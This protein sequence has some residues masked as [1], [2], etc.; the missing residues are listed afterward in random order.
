MNNK[1]L[2]SSKPD[3][4][5]TSFFQKAKKLV[6][7]IPI[8]TMLLGGALT[9][10]IYNDL[11]KRENNNLKQESAQRSR[12]IINQ[13]DLL[14]S[15][16]ILRIQSYEE[17]LGTRASDFRRDRNFLSQSLSYTIFQRMAVF[18]VKWDGN[19]KNLAQI[20]LLTRID[21]MNS[22]LPKPITNTISS[23]FMRDSM[24]KLVMGSEYRRAVLHEAVDVSRFSLILKSRSSK[25]V[26]FMFTTPLSAVFEKVDL[27][28]GESIDITDPDSG[29][30]WTVWNKGDGSQVEPA[31]IA[32]TLKAAS[33]HQYVFEGGLP[34]SGIKINFRFNFLE[35]ENN[36]SPALIAS[37]MV[38]L[39]T[40]L[41]S[42]LFYVLV[43]Q[44][45]IVSRLVVEKTHDLEKTRQDLQE[46]LLGKS[47]FLG[48]ISHEI[49]TPLNLILGMID[50]CEERDKD[51]KLEEYLTS[52]R[53]SGNHLLSMIEDLLDLAKSETNDLQIQPKKMNLAQFL[54]EIAKI[55]GQ[56]CLKKNLR[57][58][59]Q[60]PADLPSVVIC[61][62]SRLRQILLNLL[63]NACKYTNSGYV[64]LRVK[65]LS[66]PG[67]EKMTVRFEVED[68][69]VGIPQD[70][71]SRVFEA[72][73]QVESSYKLSE[74]G[75]GLGLAIVKEL[76]RKL[77]GR[78][79]VHSRPKKGSIFEVDLDFEVPDRS[80][81]VEAYKSA[82]ENDQKTIVAISQDPLFMES[83]TAL[84]SHSN[85]RLFKESNLVEP[86]AQV[87]NRWYILDADADGFSL[88]RALALSKLANVIVAGNRKAILDQRADFPL[89]ILDNAPI[90]S[91]EILTA[92]GLSPA[93]L[94]KRADK[95]EST[96]APVKTNTEVRDD[97]SLIVA[98]DDSGNQELYMAYFESKP[99]KTEYAMNGQE[100]Y[101]LFMKQP[102]DILILDVRMPLMDGFEVAEK[103]RAHEKEHQLKTTPI[104]LVTADALEETVERAGRIPGVTFL[105]KPIRKSVLFD[106]IGKTQ[107][108]N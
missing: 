60:I 38:A 24:Q 102:S 72:F 59:A 96:Q 32:F 69:G 26:I 55:S 8:F 86:K 68:T 47:R 12:E 95:K 44:N 61:D 27:R 33:R 9:V 5:E 94:V 48:N 56:D 42:Y 83:L 17:F 80:S 45:R 97:L 49:R 71:L 93:R 4:V 34:Q 99:W 64:A 13:L 43:T 3:Q 82:D 90:L 15:N 91:I 7:F 2:D 73:F 23:P 108:A 70:K 84:G 65:I 77:D 54:S 103:V 79:N 41:V 66:L 76:V 16:S 78:I 46:A 36:F 52:M 29:I 39:L 25:N 6:L 14:L 40:L 81:W 53:S 88:D 63:R 62:P 58:Y 67:A 101:D 98:D 92:I 87:A 51:K 30:S 85:L 1:N 11:M 105:T 37:A 21:G 18:G 104:I 10:Y 74:G 19:P 35:K 31:K 100:A 28:K 50:L 22:T 75:V 57:F 106:S 107:S 20:K 89:L